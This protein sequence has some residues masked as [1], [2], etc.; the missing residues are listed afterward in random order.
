MRRLL[1]AS[2]LLALAAPGSATAARFA[3]GIQRSTSARELA[4]RIE[5]RTGRSVSTVGPFALELNAPS[6]RGLAGIRGVAWVERIRA[7]RR[8]AFTPG[9]PL[10]T[11]QWYLG[12]VRAFDAWATMPSLVTVRVAVIDSGID[13]DHPEFQNQIAGGRSFVGGPWQ[14]DINGHGT[15]VAGEIAAALNN[16]QGIAGIAFTA[17]LLVAKVVRPDGTIA[18]DDEARAI[19]WAVANGAQVINMSF[20]AGWTPKNSASCRLQP[21]PRT[22]LPA[23]T[24]SQVGRTSPRGPSVE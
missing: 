1:F 11:R 17:R 7:N 19:R 15:F 13:A 2:L 21:A 4:Q 6:A 22:S 23:R 14:K 12:R 10:A 5:G 18:P 8:L 20:G 24:R 9:D 16:G 3:I